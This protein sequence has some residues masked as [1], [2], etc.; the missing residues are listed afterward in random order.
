[1]NRIKLKLFDHLLSQEMTF[2]DE[3]DTGKITAMVDRDTY[4][5]ADCLNI[6]RETLIA[7]AR[8]LSASY[9]LYHT[10]WR[11]ALITICGLPIPAV[12][13]ASLN[14]KVKI[15]GKKYSKLSDNIAQIS[16][17]TIS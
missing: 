8:F 11:I 5:I 13:Q 17:N 3:K 7:C 12:V 9:F 14:I 4:V 6:I 15:F 16:S 1:M 2:Y 10:S